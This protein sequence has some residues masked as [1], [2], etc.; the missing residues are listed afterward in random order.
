MSMGILLIAAF[1]CKKDDE[2]HGIFDPTDTIDDISAPRILLIGSLTM[3]LDLGSSYTEP[4]YSAYD[5]IDG[6]ITSQVTVSGVVNTNEVGFYPITYT[7]S[8]EAG[9]STTE[10]R[11]VYIRANAL[12][13][14]Y[15][16]HA[17]VTGTYAGTYDFTE[18]ITASINY[19]N[20]I[21]SG[22]SGFPG[23]VVNATVDGS[24][25]SFNQVVSYDWDADVATPNTNAT[26]SGTTSSAYEVITTSGTL[27]QIINLN[28]TIDYG[29]SSIDIV[30]ATYT[31]Q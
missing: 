31:K 22:L 13:G 26:I 21:F 19:N 28:Y 23:L 24:K 2:H 10:T 18:T 9:N 5:S 20:L 6:D 8:D 15:S 16:V 4:G 25:I 7:V 11:I 30:A 3:T 29:S 27:A 17:V 1:S 14:S 12:A